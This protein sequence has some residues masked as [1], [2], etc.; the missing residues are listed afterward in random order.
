MSNIYFQSFVN[1]LVRFVPNCTRVYHPKL[2]HGGKSVWGFILMCYF[3]WLGGCQQIL[4]TYIDML[5]FALHLQFFA[6]SPIF[7]LVLA[8]MALPYSLPE[9]SMMYDVQYM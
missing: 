2:H 8:M 7:A 6:L 9:K 1:V 3:Y 4:H 5:W